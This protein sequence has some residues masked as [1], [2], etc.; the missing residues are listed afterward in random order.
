MSEIPRSQIEVARSTKQHSEPTPQDVPHPGY[1]NAPGAEC[2]WW[3]PPGH[4]TEW[5]VLGLVTTRDER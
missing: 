2:V 3:C 1:R 5:T 4:M